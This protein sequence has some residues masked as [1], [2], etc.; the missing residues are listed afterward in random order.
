MD[1]TPLLDKTVLITGAARR[2]GRIFALGC[3]QA[4]ANLIIHHGNSL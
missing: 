2:V 4:G 1:K 3:A